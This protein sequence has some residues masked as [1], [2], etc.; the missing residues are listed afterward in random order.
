MTRFLIILTVFLAACGDVKFETTSSNN[1]ASGGPTPTPPLPPVNMHD[2]IVTP[3]NNAV[4]IL[5]VIDNSGSMEDEQQSISTRLSAFTDKIT[6]LDWRIAITS[7]DMGGSQSRDSQPKSGWL[8]PFDGAG[9]RYLSPTTPDFAQLFEDT[10]QLGSNGSGNERGVA[11][12]RASVL[13]N[14]ND[15]IR[16]EAQLA[17]VVLTDEDECSNQDSGCMSS[18]DDAQGLVDAVHSAYDTAAG[19]KNFTFNSIAIL[20]EDCRQVQGS[21]TLNGRLIDAYIGR[22]YIAASDL[23]GGIK[24]SICSDDY[25]NELSAMGD[26]VQSL[27]SSAV[28]QCSP[29]GGVAVVKY[30]SDGSL[31][32]SHVSGNRVIFDA[33]VPGGSSL[34][35]DYQCAQ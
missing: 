14:Q 32:A 26:L 3:S 29:V 8:V 13:R 27:S 25:A 33:P 6:A 35:I 23:T 9:N 21:Q 4:D 2:E 24:G 30:T 34:S 18:Q 17:V 7:T 11:A 15:W 28:L 19:K 20:D 22:D 10:V 31:V 1:E 5:F 12:A 16:P